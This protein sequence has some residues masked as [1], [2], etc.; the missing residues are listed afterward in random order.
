ME[1]IRT[2][3]AMGKPI[4]SIGPNRFYEAS[5][6]TQISSPSELG[7]VLGKLPE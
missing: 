3:T 5:N 6:A 4:V 2:A 7:D 1:E